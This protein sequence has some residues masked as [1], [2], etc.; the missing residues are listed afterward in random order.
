MTRLQFAAIV[1]LLVALVGLTA[2]PYI[3]PPDTA[4]KRWQYA[5]EG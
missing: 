3:H 5:V 2:L 1:T 4:S